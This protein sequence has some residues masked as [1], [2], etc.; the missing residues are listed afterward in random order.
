MPVRL[1]RGSR[2]QAGRVAVMRGPL[3]YALE[4]ERNRLPRVLLDV[5]AIGDG[6][7]FV[8]EEEAIRFNCTEEFRS[9]QQRT[10]SFTRFSEENRSRTFFPLL[11][12]AAP[13]VED[14]LYRSAVDSSRG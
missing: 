6:G 5:L 9:R 2:A 8:P 7:R 14:E 12:G 4:Q 3:V 1:V 11:P 13:T 10:V